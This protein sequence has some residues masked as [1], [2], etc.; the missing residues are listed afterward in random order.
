M[1][2]A[3]AVPDIVVMFAT[4]RLHSID[5]QSEIQSSVHLKHDM[6]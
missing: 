1:Y 3:L 2:K 5:L 6:F 4:S